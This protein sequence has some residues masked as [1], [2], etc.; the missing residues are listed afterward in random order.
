MNTTRGMELGDVPP[1]PSCK[2][3][4]K[5]KP[6][7]RSHIIPQSYYRRLKKGSNGQLLKVKDDEATPPIFSNSDPKDR[8]L[9]RDCEQF[10]DKTYEKAGTRFFMPG[11][12]TVVTSDYVK[13]KNFKYRV[14]YLYFISILW[15]ASESNL[16]QYQGLTLGD[17]GPIVRGCISRKTLSINPQIRIDHF[18]KV[19]V[20]RIVEASQVVPD[21][22]IKHCLMD[23]TMEKGKTHQDGIMFYFMVDGFLVCYYLKAEQSF[24]IQK[25]A[26]YLSQLEERS[27]IRIKKVDIS[28]LSQIS[29]AFSTLTRKVLERR[30][31]L[32]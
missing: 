22:V 23:M 1:N 7:Q 16:P 27:S 15:R 21:I 13:I 6:L 31:S 2:L 25:T 10:I 32:P 19:C 20:V 28:E 8:L 4:G 12:S 26:K 11:S 9:C 18:I 14:I 24:E 29:D 5:I 30:G 3:C 17:F